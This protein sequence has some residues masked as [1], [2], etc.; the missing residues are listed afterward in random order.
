MGA[1][2]DLGAVV[3]SVIS[4]TTTA[5]TPAASG[6]ERDVGRTGDPVLEDTRYGADSVRSRGTCVLTCLSLDLDVRLF[7]ALL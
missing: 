7:G 2:P 6:R 4:C 1:R 5:G 3:S